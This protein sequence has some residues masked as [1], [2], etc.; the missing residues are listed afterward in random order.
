MIYDNGELSQNSTVK[1][2]NSKVKQK[3]NDTKD[4]N[5]V[6][7]FAYVCTALPSWLKEVYNKTRT[8]GLNLVGLSPYYD[9][10]FLGLL[11][12]RQHKLPLCP[13]SPRFHR[14]LSRDS[15]TLIL[16]DGLQDVL[17]IRRR[18]KKTTNS[19]EWTLKLTLWGMDTSKPYIYIT[20][21]KP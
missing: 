11:R 12:K 19:V 21:P 7:Q 4:C 15:S 13:I 20:R 18:M 1:Q 17:R 14:I 5:A 10:V 6:Q 2:A 9:A 3:V 16:S 8:P